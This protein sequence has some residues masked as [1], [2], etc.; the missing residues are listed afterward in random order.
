MLL[1]GLLLIVMTGCGTQKQPTLDGRL[2]NY[3]LGESTLTDS[4]GREVPYQMQGVLGIPEEKTAR[5][6]F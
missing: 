1:T 5:W 4:N 2:L 6:L 3:D